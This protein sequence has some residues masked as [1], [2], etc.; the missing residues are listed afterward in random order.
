MKLIEKPLRKKQLRLRLRGAEFHDP[1]Q[2]HRLYLP[3]EPKCRIVEL[4][5][6]S[7]GAMQSAAKCPIMIQFRCVGRGPD[8]MKV[9]PGSRDD[10][11]AQKAGTTS[12]KLCIFKMGDDCRQ[13]QLALQLIALFRRIFESI[14]LPHFLYPYRVVA[15]G[16]GCGVIECVPNAMS[17]DQ[18]GKLVEGN[19]SEYFVQTYGH[20]ESETFRRARECFIRSMA[21]YAVASFVLNV[22]DRHNGNILIDPQGH[23]VH[24]DFGFLFDYSPGGDMN[25]ESSPFKLTLEMAQ[26]MG[27]NVHNGRR[28]RQQN[29]LASALVDRG[30]YSSF[31]NL[32]IRC[33]LAVRHYGR[34]ICVLVELMLGSGFP[35][36]KLKKTI[37][38]LSKRLA[39]QKSELQAADFMRKCITNSRENL[40]TVLYDQYQNYAEGIEM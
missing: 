37:L 4:I 10:N 17:R 6:E 11:D 7:A 23:L 33:F 38:N 20:P 25:F 15:T 36:F 14:D 12:T 1:I 39:L 27:H 28:K 24:I 35:C 30:A 18:I 34:E 29:S 19:L 26:L 13:D 8:E 16:K 5:P 2:R 9:A 22:K 21:S 40:R 3:T 31:V 32:A